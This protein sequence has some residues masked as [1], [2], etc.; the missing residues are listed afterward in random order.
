M[1]LFKLRRHS[2]RKAVA[3]CLRVGDA[4]VVH[5]PQ[6]MTDQ[7]A[8]LASSLRAG[9]DCVLVVVDFL[10]A[11]T[12]F[13]EWDA[14]ATLAVEE[15]RPIRLFPSEEAGEIPLS[16]A[17]ALSDRVGL[18]VYCPDGA[19]LVGPTGVIFLPPESSEGWAVCTPVQ[20][21]TFQGRRYPVPAWEGQ[22]ASSP[23]RVGA[24]TSAEPLPAG[25][26]FHTE[27]PEAWLEASRAKL[28]RWLR[29][30]PHECTVVLGAHGVSPL[31]LADVAQWWA[32]VPQEVRARVR[33]FCFGEFAVTEG[34]SSG[35][36]LA[37]ALGEEVVCYAGFPIG[38][39]DLP[40][41]FVLRRDGTHG[42]RAFADQL[43]YQPR[44]DPAADPVGP[45]VRRSRHPG[46]NLVED[47]PGIYRH[48]SG[49][50]IEVVQAGLWVRPLG[51]PAHATAVRTMP[52]DPAALLV[53]HDPAEQELAVR[54][55]DELPYKLR[56]VT[57][58]VSVASP[59]DLSRTSAG[60]EAVPAAPLTPLPRLSELLRRQVAPA[61]TATVVADPD[62]AAR[63][64][65]ASVPVDDDAVS[66]TM[67]IPQTSSKPPLS[68][69]AESTE[70]L[71]P[72]VMA[73][74]RSVWQPVPDP[75]QRALPATAGF[76]VQQSFVRDGRESAFDALSDRVEGVMRRFSPNRKVSEKSLIA[77]VAAGLYLAGEDPDVD[78][79]L[80]LGKAG[81]HV[82]F[83]RCVA[84]GM[85][86]FPLHRKAA[87]TVIEPEDGLWDLLEG[88]RILREWGFFHARTV[89]GPAESGSTDLVI[90]SLTGRL[91]ASIEP[92][93]ESV[94]DRVVFPPGTSF[95]VLE[96]VK[97]DGA[98]R[99]R[100]LVRELAAAEAA[101]GD[102][103]VG[104]DDLV[105]AALR[106]FA[107]RGTRTSASVPPAEA[108]RFDRVPGM[109]DALVGKE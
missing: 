72:S 107:D 22:V 49:A 15:Q 4:V 6:G 68:E 29:V 14:V 27:G 9:T 42:V 61:T 18:P 82:D 84:A 2:R 105:R 16:A 26:W 73:E 63:L 64:E 31:P 66:V 75:E 78:V 23:F 33:F 7:A 32:A 5:G 24:A 56:D 35:Q 52:A 48:E 67:E 98:Q 21:P 106:T 85:T 101:E 11:R 38:S 108:S 88:G 109:T 20:S 58:T 47:R 97:P 43:A 3:A 1:S 77:A 60:I 102:K 13:R 45:H 74:K 91:T 65:P 81:P 95:K 62:I 39:P 57:K 12:S 59:A 10:P 41:A 71:L 36:A 80:R 93:N 104:R 103:S 44:P 94:A 100:I 46:E 79:G 25:L 86:K 55:I 19:M 76:T 28:I 17:Q 92:V 53:F 89:L 96:S 70:F 83:G 99:G 69:S 30:S 51:E 40:E 87:A 90:W 8:Q 50:V 54:V 34:D 37:D